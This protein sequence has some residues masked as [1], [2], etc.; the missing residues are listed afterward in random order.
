MDTPEQQHPDQEPAVSEDVKPRIC[1]NCD[2][3]IPK[4]AIFCPK[5]G[6]R[7]TDGKVRMR[8]LLWKLWV[9]TFHL[10]TKFLR[11]IWYVLQPGRLTQEYFAGRQKRYYH[12][13]QFFLVAL[14]L[15]ILVVLKSVKSN[16][17]QGITLVDIF[18]APAETIKAL[19]D[20]KKA[21]L[22]RFDSLPDNLQSPKVK[23]ALDLCL[24]DAFLASYQNGETDISGFVLNAM[25]PTMIKYQDILYL[26]P[27]SIIQKYQ[28]QGWKNQFLTRQALHSATD[29]RGLS[30]FWLGTISWS[31][32]VLVGVMAFWMKLMYI[33]RKRF[34]VEHFLFLLHLHTAL[35]IILFFTVIGRKFLHAPK[36]IIWFT[37]LWITVGFFMAMRRFYQQG[38]FKTLGKLTLYYLLYFVSAVFVMLGSLAVAMLLF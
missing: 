25:P 9:T 13:I 7:Q 1:P 20:Y 18:H 28:I 33:R 26:S 22:A 17:S 37:V 38:F 21:S 16:S 32:L 10:D 34:F 27:D 29:S 2:K 19:E 12:P 3:K 14:F 5:C 30:N 35:F 36:A 6:Q 11:S 24:H 15:L 23:E 8:D 31:M 4:K